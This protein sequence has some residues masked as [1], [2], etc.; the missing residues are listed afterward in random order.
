MTKIYDGII[1]NLWGTCNYGAILT[2]Y[3]IQNIFKEKGLNC[4]LL[5]Y[6]PWKKGLYLGS[7][8]EKFANRYLDLT[9]E[10]K[11]S[12]DFSALN[13]LTDT[14]IV[15]SD[16][17]FRYKYINRFM[18]IYSLAFTEFSKKRI[19]F[20][21]SFGTDNF[22]AGPQRTYEFKKNLKR[23]DAISTRELSG[24]DLCKNTFNIDA[25]HLIDPVFLIDKGKYV[26]E[27]IDENLKDKY[28]NKII[29]YILDKNDEILSNIEQL[30]VKTGC[31][32]IDILSPNISVEEWLSA[33]Y[34]GEYILTDS[35]H[36]TCFSMIFEKNFKCLINTSRGSSRFETLIE[37]FENNSNFITSS[38]DFSNVENLNSKN[39]SSSLIYNTKLI[40]EKEKFEAWFNQI[41]YTSK[42]ITNKNIINELDFLNKKI[43]VPQSIVL[44]KSF[45][46]KIFSYKKELINNKK[47]KTLTI[48]GIKIKWKT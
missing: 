17:V 23:F 20:S 2:A 18:D 36:G 30:K 14:F 21:A 34:Y 41:F 32:T 12:A 13:A 5:N 31:E 28:E 35:F 19:A 39:G 15:G 27:I 22:E 6:I 4:P 43:F 46:D 45:K 42:V 48:C 9:H 40:K 1:V 3:A 10:V 29:Y 38:E 26:D 47:R 33:I 37:I 24:V 44:K 16:Q 11:T 8:F 7:V 25:K